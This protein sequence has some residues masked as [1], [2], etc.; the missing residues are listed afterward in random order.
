MCI[1]ILFLVAHIS[2]II[3]DAP[4]NMGNVFLGRPSDRHL[5]IFSSYCSS[6]TCLDSEIYITASQKSSQTSLH[7]HPATHDPRKRIGLW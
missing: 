5:R 3:I 2:M 1:F 7:L 4:D 6:R